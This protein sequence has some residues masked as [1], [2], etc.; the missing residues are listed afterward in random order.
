MDRAFVDVPIWTGQPDWTALRGVVAREWD[1]FKPSRLRVLVPMEWS[2]P[3]TNTDQTLH[4]GTLSTM[5]DRSVDAAVSIT[6]CNDPA[7]FVA[8]TAEALTELPIEALRNDLRASNEDDFHECLETGSVHV[9]EH[10]SEAA[11][12]IATQTANLE[13]FWNCLIV[14]HETVS[15]KYRSK[16]LA[17]Q[18]Q[19]LTARH[20]IAKGRNPD[21]LIVGTI[22]AENIPSFKAATA[23]GRPAV[24]KYV[25]LDL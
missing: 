5:A 15:P 1:I 8:L 18:A 22:R 21:D 25:F 7:C 19:A 17:R 13:F 12:V 2:M 10:C 24:L 4:V 6:A 20:F 11:G 3:A 23:A 14:E 16:G 9:I